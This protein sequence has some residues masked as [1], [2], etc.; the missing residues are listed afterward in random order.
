MN[1]PDTGKQSL[2][3]SYLTLRKMIG[4]LGF[5][6]PVILLSGSVIFGGYKEVQGSI[7]SYYYTNMRDVFVGIICSVALFLFSYRGY[8]I[9]NIVGNLGC[10]FA[11][12]VVFFPCKPDNPPDDYRAITGFL[13]LVSAALFFGV[14]IIFSLVLFVKT[15]EGRPLSREKKQRNRIFRICGYTMLGAIIT[16]ALYIFVFVRYLPELEKLHPVFWLESV[17][18]FAFGISWLTKGQFILRDIE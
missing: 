5:S 18:L 7:S 14:L 4:L 16:I 9:D 15:K 17:A 11:L 1:D 8:T 3:I 10:L 2:V 13:H 12:G 6:L